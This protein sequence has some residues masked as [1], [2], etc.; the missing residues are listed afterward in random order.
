M[1]E[2]SEYPAETPADAAA[3]RISGTIN[4]NIADTE[5]LGQHDRTPPAVASEHNREHTKR[6]FKERQIARIVQL[7]IGNLSVFTKSARK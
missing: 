4:M 2:I 7:D 3:R 1:A 5:F 6:Q